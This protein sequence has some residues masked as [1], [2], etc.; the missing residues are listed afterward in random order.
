MPENMVG[1]EDVQQMLQNCFTSPVQSQNLFIHGPKGTGKT[2]AT[3]LR[4]EE[5]DNIEDRCYIPC[6]QYNTEYKALKQ[7][8][9]CLS[10]E[11]IGGG[12]HSSD[13]QRQIVEKT[14]STDTVLVLDDIEFLLLNNG[15]SLLYFLTRME[16]ENNHLI[17]VSS[18]ESLEKQ[19]EERTY[20]SLQPRKTRLESYS[21]EE[22]YRILLERAQKAL[23]SQSLQKAALNHVAS[24]TQNITIGLHWLKTAAE[25]ADRMVTESD[26]KHVQEKAFA[27]YAEHQLERF[28]QHHKL[29][30]QAVR[31]LDVEQGEEIRA[32][33]VYSRYRELCQV[34]SED[35]VS[36]R[37][38]SHFLKHLEYLQLIEAEYHYGGSKGKT[39]E[40][41]PTSL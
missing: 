1:R 16:T 31:E 30:Y 32:G 22:A 20:S 33:M 39:R 18:Q 4:L 27:R 40:V 17:L 37:R 25:T 41:K 19:V 8:Y 6:I 26:V 7:I 10:N 28:T 13:L 2:L 24:R 5:A 35:T 36:K 23:R 3:H 34:Y 14:R 29:L 11:D 12:H 38:L 15:D 9:R 21:S